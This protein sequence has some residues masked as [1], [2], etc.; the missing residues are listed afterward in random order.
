[1]VFLNAQGPIPALGFA[2]P[3]VC[4]TPIVVPVPIPYP[5]FSMRPMSIPTQFTCY[6]MMMPNHNLLT[7]QPMT[8]GDN[9]GVNMGVASGMVMGPSQN[10]TCSFKVFQGAAPVTRMLDVSGHNGMS[11]NMV[12][13]SISPA[14]PLVMVLA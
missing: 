3:D 2:F 5:N 11:P 1:M 8:M 9:S 13:M 7:M 10:Y 12:G 14:Q 4:L 6:T